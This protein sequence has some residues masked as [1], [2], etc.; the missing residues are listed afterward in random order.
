MRCIWCFLLIV[1]V[2]FSY[3]QLPVLAQTTSPQQHK[4]PLARNSS[5]LWLTDWINNS[6]PAS[7]RRDAH[8]RLLEKRVMFDEDSEWASSREATDRIITKL[9]RAGFNVY[10]PCV[11]HGYGTLFPSGAAQADPRYRD[12]FLKGYDPLAYLVR[13]A[14]AAGIEVHAWFTVMRRDREFYPQFYSV[15]VPQDAFDVHNQQFRSFIVRLMLDLVER[16]PVDGVNFDYIRSMGMCRS[17]SCQDDYR[18]RY[19]RMLTAD[20]VLKQAGMTVPTLQDWNATAVSEIV[21]SFSRQAKAKRPGLVVS[22]DS[23][24]HDGTFILEGQDSVG[25]AN[26][27]LIDAIFVMDYGVRIDAG[28]MDKVR[29]LLDNPDKMNLLLA[30]YDIGGGDQ[31]VHRD[32]RL[33]A[34]YIRLIRRRWPG[35]GVAYY[36]RKQLS[37]E[38]IE[39][40]RT[41]VF[42]EDAVPDWKKQR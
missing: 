42:R 19:K 18:L 27:K 13:T 33:L 9:K 26:A 32:G 25:W 16:Y 21:S 41:D 3:C 15:G 2:L 8:G 4:L 24:P 22:V 38:Q 7:E 28:G 20:L 17:D 34:D 23:L 12:R 14:H 37:D 11:W 36:H 29:S 30:T 31:V 6:S 1:F 10:V 40:L 5:W 35:S 39:I